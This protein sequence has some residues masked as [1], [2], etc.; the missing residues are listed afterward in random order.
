MFVVRPAPEGEKAK[1]GRRETR[2]ASLSSLAFC[3]TEGALFLF[4]FWDGPPQQRK[5]K[6]RRRR[7]KKRRFLMLTSS[8]PFFQGQD[9]G[10]PRSLSECALPDIP[11][12]ILFFPT[13]QSSV[14]SMRSANRSVAAASVEVEAE[15]R[16]SPRPK[17]EEE[18]DGGTEESKEVANVAPPP[19]ES[20]PSSVTK[21]EADPGPSC[22]GK[23]ERL[24]WKHFL[25]SVCERVA[26][27]T[28][29]AV[30]VKCNR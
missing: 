10:A 1:K 27:F 2:V 29:T 16:R 24:H 23:R 13:W 25:S 7:K 8:V 5:K 18:E 15:R 6:R 9:F 19:P 30:V 3:T 28:A 17:E 12:K 26:A 14:S 4:L 22:K 21:S 20:S 11:L